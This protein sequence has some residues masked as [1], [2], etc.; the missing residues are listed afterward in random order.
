MENQSLETHL[1]IGNHARAIR[2]EGAPIEL[3]RC[4]RCERDFARETA[5]SNW[6]AITVSTFRF[7][8]LPAAVSREWLSEPCPGRPPPA[9]ET[10]PV[11]GVVERPQSAVTPEA[12]KGPGMARRRAAL[13]RRDSVAGAS[14]KAGAGR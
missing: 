5:E 9:V 8:Y 4:P 1:W 12:R 11:A 2:L 10:A 3:Y 14:E 7:A 13:A 6:R